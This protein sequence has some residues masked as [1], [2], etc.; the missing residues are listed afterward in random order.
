MSDLTL[1]LVPC[2]RVTSVFPTL[3][4]LN[5]DGAFTSYQSFLEKGSTLQH[6]KGTLLT[7]HQG[8]QP[9]IPTRAER[10]GSRHLSRANHRSQ[11]HKA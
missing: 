10:R 6:K 4:V 5:T 3:R 2:V 11:M 7:R 8:K 9:L 1:T